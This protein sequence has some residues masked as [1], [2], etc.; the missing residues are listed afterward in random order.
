MKTPESPSTTKLQIWQLRRLSELLSEHVTLRTH[1]LWSI[2][3]VLD[4]LSDEDWDL[5]KEII[6]W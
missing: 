5:D 3:K 2:A 6:G 1:L 4:R